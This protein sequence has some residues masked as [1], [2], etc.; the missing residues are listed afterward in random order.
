VIKLL[1]EYINGAM[2]RA[3]YKPL[4]N[5]TWFGEIPDFEGLWASG[6]TVEAACEELES[7]LE[8]WII[9][10]LRLG[11]SLPVVDGIDL[12]P[13]LPQSKAS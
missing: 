8:G 9:L 11:H 4:A 7:V 13:A 1:I 3:V 10:G 6:S 2:R 5:G 12:T